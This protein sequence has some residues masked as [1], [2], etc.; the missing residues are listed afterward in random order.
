MITINKLEI[1][2]EKQILELAQRKAQ[3]CSSSIEKFVAIRDQL[4]KHTDNPA[5]IYQASLELATLLSYLEPLYFKLE[6]LKTSYA[7]L[8]FNYLKLEC[9]ASRTKFTAE[10][11]KMETEK[12]IYPLTLLVQTLHGYIESIKRLHYT[13]TKLV[14]KQ[15]TY[16]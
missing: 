11:A 12:Y 5:V 1:L 4:V 15:R 16:E 2:S 8:Y 7:S 3:E 13:C 14:D 6:G 10:A 9:Q